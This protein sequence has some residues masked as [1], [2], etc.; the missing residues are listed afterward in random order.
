[1]RESSF[2]PPQA[3]EMLL[4][5]SEQ[6][7]S[8]TIHEVLKI[9]YFSDKLHAQNYGFM[10]SGDT[11]VAMQFGPVGTGSYD[12][13]KAARGQHNAYN[14]HYVEL[15]EGAIAVKDE[16]ITPIRAA[17]MDYLSEAQKQCIDEAVA[18]YGGLEFGKRTDISH[19]AAWSNAWQAA[20]AAHRKQSPMSETDIIRTLPNAEEVLEH[21]NA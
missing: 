19:D 18:Q 2:S 12:M 21:I 8:P 1:M 5:I 4:Y 3:V 17:N 7:E 14:L 15:V 16:V 20:E 6:L 9:Q 13:I 10:A 11:Y